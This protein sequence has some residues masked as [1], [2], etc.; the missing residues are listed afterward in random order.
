MDQIEANPD[1]WAPSTVRTNFYHLKKLE[2][3]QRLDDGGQ[4]D[5]GIYG[6]TEKGRELYAQLGLG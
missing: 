2:L 5:T 1:D 4:G 6:P 3:V